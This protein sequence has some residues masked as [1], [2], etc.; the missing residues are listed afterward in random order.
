MAL[1]CSMTS[2]NRPQIN[3]KTDRENHTKNC[4]IM[5]NLALTMTIPEV[6]RVIS[7]DMESAAF[8]NVNKKCHLSHS[9]P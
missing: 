9:P 5:K 8:N 6:H 2:V 3:D 1:A 4:R 7:R